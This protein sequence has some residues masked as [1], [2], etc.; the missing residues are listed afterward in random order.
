MIKCS[1]VRT[2][3]RA[4][5]WVLERSSTRA[6][7]SLSAREL[8][9]SSA[10]MLEWSSSERSSAQVRPWVGPG[11]IGYGELALKRRPRLTA[12]QTNSCFIQT[13]SHVREQPCSCSAVWPYGR[14]AVWPLRLDSVAPWAPFLNF[15]IDKSSDRALHPRKLARLFPPR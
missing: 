3:T 15:V 8:E 6:L 14:L 12:V 13:T 5:N 7:E 10:Q 4:S 11:V 9:C 2:P 1:T